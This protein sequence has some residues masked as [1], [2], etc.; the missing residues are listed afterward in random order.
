M[1]LLI[2]LALGVFAGLTAG[3]FGIG[4][5]M[6]IVPGLIYCFALQGVGDTVAVHMAVGTSLATI[7]MTSI[8]SVRTHHKLGNVDWQ[9]WRFLAP[10]IALGVMLGVAV[11]SQM[12]GSWLKLVF[13]IFAFLI[14]LQMWFGVT[15]HGGRNLPGKAALSATGS[16]IGFLSALFGIGGGSLTVPFLSWCNVRMQAAVATSAAC[17]LPI[18]IVG[19][20]SNMVAGYGHPDLP[21][22]TTGYVFWPG[23]L[24]IVLL[25][26][27]FARIGAKL[28]QGLSG[29]KLKRSFAVFQFVVA[30]YL[31]YG[32][33]F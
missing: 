25:S 11:A 7:V 16:G 1:F 29:A 14:A 27:P 26:T 30:C 5:G 12:S 31:F 32:A 33:L 18:A 9:T 6:I 15:A 22:W 8:S 3:V 24:G 21:A 23:F 2:Y 20:I 13:A 10:G 28:A 17:G 4:G 19:A